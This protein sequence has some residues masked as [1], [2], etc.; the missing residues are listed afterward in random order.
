MEARVL[1][2]HRVDNY[3]RKIDARLIPVSQGV[4]VRCQGLYLG[5]M[6]SLSDLLIC[7]R[8]N[9]REKRII[10]LLPQ[11]KCSMWHPLEGDGR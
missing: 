10:T 2:F 8:K 9:H 7:T 4:K 5:D 6:I 1:R 3:L 11:P